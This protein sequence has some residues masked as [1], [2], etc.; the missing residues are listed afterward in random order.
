[1]NER[2]GPGVTICALAALIVPVL[3]AQAAA[4]PKVRTITVTAD[5]AA[6]DGMVAAADTDATIELYEQG[7][8]TTTAP[9]TDRTP[10]A[11]G[12]PA[13]GG[14]FRLPAPRF[15]DGRD[16]LYSSCVVAI[17]DDGGVRPLGGSHFA[18]AL[19]GTTASWGAH[20]QVDN[21]GYLS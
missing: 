15:I 7:A 2:Y 9:W 10:I 4:Q 18:D 3:P 20:L 19:V 14:V 21:V 8:E 16:R 11:T 6:A 5:Q 17:R 1:M 13:A 12:R